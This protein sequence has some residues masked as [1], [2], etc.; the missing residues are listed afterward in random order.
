M[1]MSEGHQKVFYRQSW[2]TKTARCATPTQCCLPMLHD[3]CN[4]GK[5]TLEHASDRDEDNSSSSS[6]ENA[7]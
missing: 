3:S 6:G 2:K 1:H 7:V 4:A 5:K